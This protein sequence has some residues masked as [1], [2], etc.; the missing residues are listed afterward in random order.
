VGRTHNLKRLAKLYGMVVDLNA[1]QMK[2]AAA[3]VFEVRQASE[4]LV[5]RRFESAAEGRAGLARG[6]RLEALAAEKVAIK[7]E[8]RANLLARLEAERQVRFEAAVAAHRESR[9]EAGQV[10]GLVERVRVKEECARDR[11]AQAESDDRF[12]SRREWLRSNG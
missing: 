7:E 1:M 12:L 11:R 3:A 2:A 4:E 10:K 8:A 5:A 9:V 6:S